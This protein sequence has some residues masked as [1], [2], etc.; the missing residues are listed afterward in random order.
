MN[1]YD[2]IK[3]LESLPEEQKKL[4]LFEK[5]HDG[6]FAPLEMDGSEFSEMTLN[7]YPNYFWWAQ[8]QSGLNEFQK[9]QETKDVLVLWL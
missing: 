8:W 1:A 4:D 6:D 5:I 7:Y 3:L 9:P 2:L